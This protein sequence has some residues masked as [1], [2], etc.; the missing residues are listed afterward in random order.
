MLKATIEIVR[1]RKAEGQSLEEIQ[2]AGLPSD[3]DSWGSGFIKT[4]D[5]LEF[6][7]QS[8]EERSS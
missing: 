7:H 6:I 4:A 1:Q 8:L 3:W 2:A 5:W